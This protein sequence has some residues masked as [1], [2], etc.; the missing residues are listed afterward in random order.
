MVAADESSGLCPSLVV[1]L[2]PGTNEQTRECNLACFPLG[3][4]DGVHHDRHGARVEVPEALLYATLAASLSIE[5][6]GKRNEN[7][8]KKDQGAMLMAGGS[9]IWKL[10]K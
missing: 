8:K 2:Y 1:G 5:S 10:V 4:L 3:G 9:R 7:T 6:F